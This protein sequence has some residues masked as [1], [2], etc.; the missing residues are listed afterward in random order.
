MQ[1]PDAT[2]HYGP[3]GGRY[4]SETL[5]P[6]LI[7]L[8]NAKAV[9]SIPSTAAGVVAKVHVKPGDKLG[10]GQ[11]IVTLSG[12]AAAAS[13]PAPPAATSRSAAPVAEAAGVAPGASASACGGKP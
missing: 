11:R 8:E 4:V 9:A 13:A 5:M 12:G 7:E 2:G 3:Y 10:V 1:Y 6:A